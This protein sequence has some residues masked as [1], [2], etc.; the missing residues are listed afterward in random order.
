MRISDWSSDVCSSDLGLLGHPLS[1]SQPDQRLPRLP[2]PDASRDAGGRRAGV[3]LEP[4]RSGPC[5]TSGCVLEV[6]WPQSF[7]D[8]AQMRIARAATAP[9]NVHM[10]VAGMQFA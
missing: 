2:P 8:L 7:C 3:K 6:T 10:R 4:G 1:P 9:K 5:R